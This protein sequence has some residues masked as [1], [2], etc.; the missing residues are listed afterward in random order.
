MAYKRIAQLKTAVQFQDYVAS[1]GIDL[2][3]DADMQAGT[4]APLAQT[5]TLKD[6]FMIG[7]RFCTHPMEGW[8]GTLDGKPTDLV[9]R[10]WRNFGRSGAKLIWG[11]EA[12]AVVHAGRANPN[13]LLINT[14][15]LPAIKELRAALVTEHEERYGSS[16]DLLIGL[17]L[18]HSGRFCRPDPDHNLKPVIAYRHPYLDQ[19]FGIPDDYAVITD[20][21]IE[22]R[23]VS[24]LWMSSIVTAIWVMNF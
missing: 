19:K 20:A 5:Y 23:P 2:P 10:R 4:A 17:Q 8:D 21:E 13:Q 3:F 15:N 16:D 18:T 22:Q 9:F 6:G 11:G 7:N 1:L 14:E 12:V 24:S